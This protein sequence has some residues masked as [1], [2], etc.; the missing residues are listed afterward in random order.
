MDYPDDVKYPET[1]KKAVL[2]DIVINT[3]Q[4]GSSESCRKQWQEICKLAEGI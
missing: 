2:K 3:V 1:C 4:C